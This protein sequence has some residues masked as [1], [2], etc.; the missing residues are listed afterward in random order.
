[1]YVTGD[2]STFDKP[3]DLSSIPIVT[4]A[5]AD[6]E[7]RSL[8]LRSTTMPTLKA[9]TTTGIS[10]PSATP[11]AAEAATYSAAAAQQY[12]QQLATVPELKPYGPVLKSTRE[13]DPT[14]VETEYVVT[15]I[16]HIFKKHIVL[17][18]NVKTLS[19]TLFW[20]MYIE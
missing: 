12:A 18:F 15:A 20:R 4:R 10:R 14:E 5:E 9:P 2:Q 13:V 11:S 8:R 1:M 3:F 16:K 19:Q 6:A 17:Q 7:D